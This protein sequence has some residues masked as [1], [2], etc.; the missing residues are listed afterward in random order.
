MHDHTTNP[1]VPLLI[2]GTIENFIISQ[3]HR[4]QRLTVPIITNPYRRVCLIARTWRQHARG[5]AAQTP[6]AC[7]FDQ[8]QSS[9]RTT[10][11]DAEILAG[12]A[13]LVRG[14]NGGNAFV[15]QA[16]GVSEL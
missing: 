2:G 6:A 16:M 4:L 12:Y 7:P 13:G 9:K 5:A 3:L 10:L 11:E 8:R 14:A 1:G 15:E